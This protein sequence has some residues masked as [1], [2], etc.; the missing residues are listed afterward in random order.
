MPTET[1]TATTAAAFKATVSRTPKALKRGT[2]ISNVRKYRV[3]YVMLL[4]GIILLLINN[5][6]PMLG[7][8]IAFK[9]IN[10]ADGFLAS[11]WSGFNNFK[12]LFSTEVAWTITRNTLIYNTIFIL[13]NLIIGISMAILFNEMRSKVLAKFHQS[14][15]FL[16]YLLS[17]VVIGYLVFAFLGPERG[18]LNTSVFP[19]LGWDPVDWYSQPEFWPYILPIVNTWKN[20]GYFAV[21][22]LAAMLG[23]DPEYY[24][25]ALIDGAT[26]REQILNI[27]LPLIRPVIIVM[28][29]LQIG[30]IFYAD[31]GLFFQ[32]TQNAGAI[33]PTT[34]VIDTYVYQTFLVMGDIGMSSAAGLYQALVGFILVL[35]TNLVIRK[36]SKEDAL[37]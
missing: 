30:R 24:E 14:T 26:K 32:V 1:A 31:F 20:V 27:T 19:V 2:F 5:Y 29:L 18:L 16:P 9:N 23:I 4:P 10:Y 34:Q 11:P 13:A 33:Y 12:F 3:F 6:L 8:L 21:I 22:Y 36:I 7:V 25:A 15:M 17:W 35:L 37:F 28:T